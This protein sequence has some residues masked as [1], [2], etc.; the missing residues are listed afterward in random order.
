MYYKQWKVDPTGETK[1]IP[2]M[3]IISYHQDVSHISS[4]WIKE[5]LVSMNRF[6]KY[7]LRPKGEQVSNTFKIGTA[8]HSYLMERLK[9]DD[10]YVIHRKSDLPFPDSTMAKKENKAYMDE[11]KDMSAGKEIIDEETMNQIVSMCDSAMESRTVSNYVEHG[12]IEHSIFFN[13]KDTGLPM[14]TRPDMYVEL[15]N[16]TIVVLDVKT[17]DRIA[18]SEFFSS[19]SKYNYPMQAAIQ[20]DGIESSTGKKVSMYLYLAMEKKYPYEYCLY[21]LT[22]DDIDFGRSTYRDLLVQIKHACETGEWPMCGRSSIDRKMLDDNKND[23]VDIVLPAYYYG[24]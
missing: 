21:R 15:S 23:I 10:H 19:V 9:F 6:L 8:V 7:P 13:C 11:L 20:C 5:A 3:D 12:K 17:T 1:I 24:K 22:E 2:D 16:G 14:K 4:S 18:P